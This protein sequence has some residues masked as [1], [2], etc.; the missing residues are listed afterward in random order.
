[1]EHCWYNLSNKKRTSDIEY[2]VGEGE[3]QRFIRIAADAEYGMATIFDSSVLIFAASQFIEAINRGLKVG[4]EFH[5]TGYEYFT[6]MG[7]GISGR[8][9][10]D[11]WAALQ[12]LQATRVETN[13]KMNATS[14]RAHSFNMLSEIKQVVEDGKH[15]G[16]SIILPDFFYENLLDARNVLTLHKDYFSLTSGLERWLYL[17][18]RRAAGGR[19][20]VWIEDLE[21]VYSKTGALSSLSEFKRQVGKIFDK[22]SLLDVELGYELSGTRAIEFADSRRRSRKDGTRARLTFRMKKE[23]VR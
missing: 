6:F 13:I 9:Y 4:R 11:L 7:K 5:F 2:L 23:R 22:G 17:Y 12:R 10:L 18:A 19:N 8:G 14:K 20:D 1:M 3:A 15:R 16:Y 21:R